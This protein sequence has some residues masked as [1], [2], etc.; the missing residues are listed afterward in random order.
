VPAV[1]GRQDENGHRQACAAPSA[2]QRKTVDFRQAEIEHHGIVLLRVAEEV[3]PLAIGGAIDDV[4]R[5]SE[6][7]GELRRERRFVF[8]YEY[9]HRSVSLPGCCT[10]L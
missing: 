3:S 5:L 8:R 9:S 1:A 6:R 4:A 2:E 7:G 10:S